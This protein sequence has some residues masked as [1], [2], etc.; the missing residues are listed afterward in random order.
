MLI[1]FTQNAKQETITSII[2]NEITIILTIKAKYLK[3]TFNKNLKYKMH[4]NHIVK[5]GTKFALA[6]V[7][8]I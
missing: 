3:V 6:I 5:K 1:H 2:L 7:S 4:L 8:I